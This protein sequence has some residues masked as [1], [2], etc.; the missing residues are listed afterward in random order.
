MPKAPDTDN[1]FTRIADEI[2]EALARTDL[3][4]SERRVIDVVMRKTWGYS[5]KSDRI[6][7]SQIE[8]ATGLPR[9]TISR[10]VINLERMNILLGTRESLGITTRGLNKHF[11]EWRPRDVDVPS[12]VARVPRDVDVPRGRDKN[13]KSLGTPMSHTIDN[14][15][16]DNTVTNVTVAKAQHGN[17]I[18]QGIIDELLRVTKLPA[19]DGS[20]QGN[21]R[22]AWRMYQKALKANGGNETVTKQA[23]VTAIRLI[24]QDEW[25]AARCTNVMYLEKNWISLLNKASKAKPTVRHITYSPPTP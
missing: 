9:R 8:K 13:G 12:R 21:R 3:S 22:A 4:G 19:L 10:A 16:K 14:L 15:T 20:Q 1:G 23:I 7:L 6:A 17:P 25:H 2:L 18:V 24:P 5:K 11:A